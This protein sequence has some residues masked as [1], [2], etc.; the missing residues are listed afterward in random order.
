MRRFLGIAACTAATTLL[1][2]GSAFAAPDRSIDLGSTKPTASWNGKLGTGFVV[3]SDIDQL[4]PCGTAVVHD[5]DYTLVHVTEPGFINVTTEADAPN[6]VDVALTI[7][8]SDADGSKLDSYGTSDSGNADESAAAEN[9]EPAGTD[10]YV[11]VEINYTVIA[12][13]QP[14]ATAT[15]TPSG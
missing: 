11:L 3:F 6:S 14:K 13:G 4:P 9:T 10:K 5:C 12:G 1:L 2:A 15:F 7:Y 8:D